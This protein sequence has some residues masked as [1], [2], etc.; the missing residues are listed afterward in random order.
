MGIIHGAL[1]DANAP[2]GRASVPGRMETEMGNKQA[3]IVNYQRDEDGICCTNIAMAMSA[4]DVEA[5]YGDCVWLVVNLAKDHEVEALKRR[6]CPV[7]EC[8]G[9][10]SQ[11]VRDCIVNAGLRHYIAERFDGNVTAESVVLL[12]STERDGFPCWIAFSIGGT[13]YSMD[14]GDGIPHRDRGYDS[15]RDF[16]EVADRM[17]RIIQMNDDVMGLGDERA[18]RI[19]L[20]TYPDGADGDDIED[21]A[22][23]DEIYGWLCKDHEYLM[24]RYGKVA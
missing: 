18:E 10:I 16:A 6:G 11:E 2:K 20:N 5:E 8:E 7:V 4:E 3:W 14:I 22:R 9:A 23:D 17:A 1:T 19:W 24:E 13:G 12:E 21:M 15:R